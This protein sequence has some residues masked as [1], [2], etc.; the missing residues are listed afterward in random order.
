MKL[1]AQYVATDEAADIFQVLFEKDHDIRCF[2][3]ETSQ[4]K[5]R[6]R[7]LSK[8]GSFE[9][10]WGDITNPEI[11]EQAMQDI[12]CII[13]LAAII[14]PASDANPELARKVNVGGTLNLLNAAKNLTTPPKFIFA[15]SIATTCVKYSSQ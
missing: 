14:P 15:S 13:H 5:K 9:T 6:Q 7:E 8:V 4:N 10:V 2:D 1:L 3:I 12:D 11:V